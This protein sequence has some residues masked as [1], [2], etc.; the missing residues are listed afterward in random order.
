MTE[1][2]NGVHRRNPC[3]VLSKR[4]LLWS[5]VSEKQNFPKHFGAI[6]SHITLKKLEKSFVKQTKLQTR[7]YI[8]YSFYRK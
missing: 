1:S 7:H 2:V 4:I 8:K 3:T 6:V 5:N